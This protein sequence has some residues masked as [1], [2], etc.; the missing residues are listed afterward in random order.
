MRSSL[1]WKAVVATVNSQP[2]RSPRRGDDVMG[3]VGKWTKADYARHEADQ[4]SDVWLE[5]VAPQRFTEQLNRFFT[6]TVPEMPDD[7]FTVE[8]LDRAEAVWRVLWP[9]RKA[10]F[11]DP[12]IADQFI[13]Y[14][15][16][17]YRRTLGGEW[18]NLAQ[19]HSPVE[20]ARTLSP[21]IRADYAETGVTPGQFLKAGDDK[22]S[23]R[24]FRHFYEY[25]AG[26]AQALQ[27]G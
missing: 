25:F 7:P 27:Q 3:R 17:T 13:R 16:E 4:H 1:G 8:G 22:D 12:D 15:G 24:I 5:W 9:S 11:P 26:R 18:I 6:E 2:C 10:P 19:W 23:G 21:I 20:S 14:I